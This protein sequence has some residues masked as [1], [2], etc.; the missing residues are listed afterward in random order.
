MFG[1]RI[2]NILA[3]HRPVVAGHSHHFGRHAHRVD[4]HMREIDN[5]GHRVGNH[6]HS[7]DKNMYLIA[8]HSHR[9]ASNGHYCIQD[10]R[11]PR[12]R[13]EMDQT[14]YRDAEVLRC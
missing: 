7:V 12:A 2:S 11:I 14:C 6:S 3:K 8:S 9:I 1:P 5:Y 4:K 10:G 13:A